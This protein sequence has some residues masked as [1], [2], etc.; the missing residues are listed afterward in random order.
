[1]ECIYRCRCRCTNATEIKECTAS[2]WDI[3]MLDA[4]SNIAIKQAHAKNNMIVKKK[5]K[6]KLIRDM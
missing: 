3:T 4:L 5:G 6:G 2:K 1:V